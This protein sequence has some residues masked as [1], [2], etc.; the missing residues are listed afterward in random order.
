MHSIVRAVTWPL[1]TAIAI[2]MVSCGVVGA[3]ETLYN[4]IVL[5]DE[6]PPRIAKLTREPMP[7]PYLDKRPEVVPIDVGRQLFVDDFLIE[8]TTLKRTYH[9]AKYHPGCPILKPDRP[10]ERESA[11]GAGKPCAMVFSDGVWY[12][13]AAKLFKMWY[14]GGYCKNTCYATSQDGIQWDKPAL[15]VVSGTNVALQKFRDSNT[16][17]LDLNEQQAA[18]RYKMFIVTQRRDKKGGVDMYVYYSADGIHWGKPEATAW[19]GCDRTTFFFNPFRNKWI[20]SIRG[21]GNT[22][23]SRNYA[24]CTDLADTLGRLGEL[25]RPWTGADRLDPHNPNP[26]YKDVPPELYNLDAT[27][28][29]SLMLGLFSIWEGQPKDTEKRNEVLLGYSRDGFHWYR[30]DRRPFA[31]V[32]ETD[33]AWNWGNVQ[34]AGGGCL[35]VGDQLYFYVSGRGPSKTADPAVT[36]LAVLR[37]DGFAS[38]DAGETT[39]TLTTRLVKFNGKYLF[40][41]ADVQGGEL[42]V[43]VLD[44][45]GKVYPALYHGLCMPITTDGTIQPVQWMESRDLAAVAGKPVRFRFHLTNGKLYSFWVSP[46]QSGASN[47]YVAAGGPGFTEPR[48][49]VG[50]AAYSAAAAIPTSP[51]TASAAASQAAGVSAQPGSPLGSWVLVNPHTP[52]SPRDTAEDFVFAG[53]MWISNGWRSGNI[54]TRDLWSS[55]DGVN[56]TLVSDATPYDPYSEMVVYDGKVWAIKGS[57]WNS[58]DGLHWQKVLD[59]TPFGDRG[60]GETVVFKDRIWQLGSGKDVW[61]TT[62]GVNWTCATPEAAYGDR[63]ATAVAAFDGKLWVMAGRKAGANTPPEKGYKDATTLNDV[64][65]SA[66]GASWTRVLENAPWAPREWGIAAVYAGRLWLIGGHDNVNSR[67]LG[68]VWTTTDGKEWKRFQSL[69]QFAP[70][71]E[72]TPYV[73]DG[74][75]WVVAGNTWPVVN[76]VWRLTLPP[77]PSSAPAR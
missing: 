5:P 3:G 38:M 29:E 59:K 76:D 74:S 31:G 33:G 43:E 10:W 69:T 51:A 56:W 53:K 46:D 77:P 67:N 75:L 48:D 12:D 2:L 19:T 60:Y 58:A 18:R 52:F 47:G 16:V 62:D 30:P 70:R 71:H 57:V 15:D 72:V 26:A 37:R 63:S 23:R 17:W 13:P 42:R 40:I 1:A 32:N 4:G 27:P 24:E 65:C 21:S 68:D 6:W 61:S 39:G 11:E 20:Y 22:G 28:Y 66:D 49:T 45:D 14:M 25:G 8:Q 64:W 50:A 34:S 36:G 44:R 35:V 73:Y 7:V 55:T 54:L 9:T 41:N